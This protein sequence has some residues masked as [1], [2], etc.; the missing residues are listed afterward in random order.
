MISS[1]LEEQEDKVVKKIIIL[2][3]KVRKEEK[4]MNKQDNIINLMFFNFDIFFVLFIG[5]NF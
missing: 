3:Y 1:D 2:V 5:N 4:M